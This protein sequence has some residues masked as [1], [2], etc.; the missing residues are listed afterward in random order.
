MTT[1]APAPAP[2]S[3]RLKTIRDGLSPGESRRLGAMAATIVAFHL[4]GWGVFALVIM[5]AH[6]RA[7]GL[8]VA[9]TAYTLGMRHAFDADHIAAIDNTTRKFMS[10]GKRPLSV[11]FWFSLGHSSVVVGLGVAITFAA[12]A[13]FHAVKDPSSALQQG[14][15]IFGTAISGAFLYLIALLNVIVLV[16]VVR[17]FF[18]MRKGIYDDEELEAQ[19]NARGLMFRFFGR[20]MKAIHSPWQM[21]PL[22]ILFG[23]GFDTATEIALLAATAGA[24]TSHLPWYSILCLPILFTA[25]MTLLDTIDG[26]FMNFAYGWAFSRPVRKVYYN[27]VI[28]GL[29]VFVAF[30]IGTVE[31]VGLV[32]AEAHLHGA[33]WDWAAKFNINRAGFIIAAAFVVVWLGAVAVWRWGRVEDRWE[34]A[35]LRAQASRAA[36][37]EED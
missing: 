26:S 21:Y 35:A 3:S 9:V 13:V 17:V 20:L 5:P 7:L 31:I 34:R 16:G 25:G 30:F 37:G 15:G 18:E 8:G 14:G 29:S 19:L 4:L 24:A 27:I 1:T 2:P 12:R 11:G 23:L 6:Y 32:S 36:L 10:E 22:G 33:F 28:T